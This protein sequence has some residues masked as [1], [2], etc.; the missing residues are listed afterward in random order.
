MQTLRQYSVAVSGI[1]N[2]TR[3]LF[4]CFRLEHIT[5]IRK[6]FESIFIF[7]KIIQF[8]EDRFEILCSETHILK[9]VNPLIR[10]FYDKHIKVILY[11]VEPYGYEED[12][13]SYICICYLL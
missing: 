12:R 6:Q 7:A 1:E 8:D 2:E 5:F 13:A 10:Y 9:L 11:I 3:F 4:H